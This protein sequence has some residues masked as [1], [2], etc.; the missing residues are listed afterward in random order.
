MACPDS[1][2]LLVRDGLLGRGIFC[3]RE[4]GCVNYRGSFLQGQRVMT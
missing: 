3:V 2:C 4:M 1:M